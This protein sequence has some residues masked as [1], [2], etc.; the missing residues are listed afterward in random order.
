MYLHVT[1][2]CGNETVSAAQSVT[3]EDMTGPSANTIAPAS[4]F[5]VD[6]SCMAIVSAS[7]IHDG[8]NTDN[9]AGALSYLISATGM[10]ADAMAS[11]TLEKTN[12][13]LLYTSPS[14]RDAT[15]SR[16]PSSA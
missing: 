15:L 8:S 1:D 4:S 11:V 16:M 10:S 12:T 6:G 5:A 2:A 7:N 9:C 3:L 13:C 14:P